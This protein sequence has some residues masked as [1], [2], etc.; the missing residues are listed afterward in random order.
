MVDPSPYELVGR[1]A[2]AVF[3]M[4]APSLCFLGLVRGLER[5]RDDDLILAWARTRNGDQEYELPTNDDVLTAL[6][7]DVG[8]EVGEMSTVR[9]PVCNTKNRIEMTYCHDCQHRLA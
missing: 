6:V 5:M 1:L 8:T 4:V 9:C 2:I 3:V 7:T